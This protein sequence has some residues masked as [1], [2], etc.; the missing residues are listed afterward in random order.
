MNQSDQSN[1]IFKPTTTLTKEDDEA[2]RQILPQNELTTQQTEFMLNELT[3]GDLNITTEPNTLQIRGSLPDPLSP[4][5]VE[6][7]SLTNTGS[8]TQNY[9]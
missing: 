6:D 5:T 8:R 2:F 9:S 3:H 4:G 1:A 7:G